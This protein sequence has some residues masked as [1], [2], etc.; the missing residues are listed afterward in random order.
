MRSRLP[1]F[2]LALA[3]AG[4]IGLHWGLLQSVAWMGMVVSYSHDA[5]LREALVKT[6]DGQHPCN[7]CK[8]ISDGKKSEKKGET[9]KP[10][11]RMELFVQASTRELF[12]PACR[13]EWLF[14]SQSPGPLHEAPPVPPPRT[15][16]C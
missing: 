6:F 5:P 12:P 11:P 13:A 9:L 3:L 2:L 16:P 14:P 10:Q 15:L 1:K 8:Q 7:L 4:S